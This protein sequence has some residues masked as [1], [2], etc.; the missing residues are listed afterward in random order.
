MRVYYD[1]G[2]AAVTAI[3]IKNR[4]KKKCILVK[5][6]TIILEFILWILN[7][8]RYISTHVRKFPKTIDIFFS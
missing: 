3:G 8:L 7:N 4:V 6:M 2:A 5:R 1:S